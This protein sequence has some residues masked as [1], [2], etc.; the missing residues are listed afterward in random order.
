VKLEGVIAIGRS[1]SSIFAIGSSHRYRSGPQPIERL[2]IGIKPSRALSLG[3]TVSSWRGRRE[4]EEGVLEQI[5]G[6]S[7]PAWITGSFDFIEV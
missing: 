6:S 2:A 4:E 1:S 3:T 7:S 5:E